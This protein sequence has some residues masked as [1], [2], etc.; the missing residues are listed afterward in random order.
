[1]SLSGELPDLLLL[2]LIVGTAGFVQSL[3]GF[4]Y[5]ITALAVLPYLM[6]VRQAH[7]VISLSG[8]PV[9]LLAT[10][11]YRQQALLSALFWALFGSLVTLP[12]GLL[13]FSRMP[14]DWLVRVTGAVV[15]LF[16][17]PELIGRRKSIR[18]QSEVSKPGCWTAGAV[19]G[20]LAGAVST[21]GPPIVAFALRQNWSPEAYRFFVTG[22]LL[23]QA[24]M[25]AAGLQVG[26]LLDPE[27]IRLSL[28]AMPAALGGVL[29]GSMAAR[30]LDVGSYRK[31]VA[32]ALIASGASLL[33]SDR[34]A[35]SPAP[36]PAVSLPAE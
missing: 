34:P 7:L 13:V 14:L 31:L 19:S 12:L 30:R 18:K 10:W 15:L 9:L 21:G 24:T 23:I 25:K 3:L 20:F 28:A 17:L 33:L 32:I 8:I 36:Q 16:A 2:G 5:A 26:G 27:T 4:G 22:Y 1:M 6:E 35:P 29:L 11:V